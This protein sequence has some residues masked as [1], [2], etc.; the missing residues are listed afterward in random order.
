MQAMLDSTKKVGL[1]NFNSSTIEI[2]Q[3]KYLPK[4]GVSMPE[5]LEFGFLP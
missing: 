4:I 3:Q 1:P 5:Q 2:F